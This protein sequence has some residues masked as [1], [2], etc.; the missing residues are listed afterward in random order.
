M[1]YSL[2][3]NTLLTQKRSDSKKVLYFCCLGESSLKIV[4]ILM[5]EMQIVKSNAGCY[6]CE[7]E[8]GSMPVTGD[9]VLIKTKDHILPKS[10]GYGDFGNIVYSCQYC[11]NWK[12]N[13]TLNSFAKKVN[14]AIELKSSNY[15]GYTNE[16]LH[17]ILTNIDKA[18]KLVKKEKLTTKAK[19]T[20]PASQYKSPTQV[21]KDEKK[22]KVAYN[23][24]AK[25][26]GWMKK[27]KKPKLKYR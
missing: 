6:Y 14:A 26:N 7:R 18:K 11:N 17:V 24:W 10:L 21:R 9:F 12:A 20:Q 3:G 4:L 25:K 13:Y 27:Q 5:G 1:V 8:F 22:E 23:F 2:F 15:K 16:Q 19:N